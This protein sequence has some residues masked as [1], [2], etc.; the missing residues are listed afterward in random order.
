MA[1][2]LDL[3]FALEGQGIPLTVG[4]GFGLFLKR[5]HLDA[6]GE[7]TLLDRLPEPRA[8]NDIDLFLRAEVLADLART[9]VVADTIRRL[10]YVPVEEAKFLQWKRPILVAGVPQEIKLDVLVGPLGAFKKKLH[11]KMPRVRPKGDIEFHA[12]AVEEAILIEEEPGAVDVRGTRTTGEV[13][14]GTVYVPQPFS[15]L[16]MKL[17]AFADRKDD[18]DKDLGRHHALDV[19]T[20]VGLMSEGEYERAKILGS[21]HAAEAPAQRARDIVREHFGAPTAT[22]MLRL[23]EHQLFRADFRIDVFAEVLQEIFPGG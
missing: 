6:L 20:I 1:S 21:A 23:R 7:R 11:V 10:G 22:G 18:A 16:L 13:H 12:H 14:Q 3:L 19:Y 2:L 9:R 8:T 17:H 15:Y 4:G 5:R